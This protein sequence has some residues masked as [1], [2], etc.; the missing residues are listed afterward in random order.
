MIY[1]H[2]KCQSEQKNKVCKAKLILL[3][4]NF[5]SFNITKQNEL[6]VIKVKRDVTVIK[7]SCGKCHC[8]CEFRLEKLSFAS[9]DF[10]NSIG[11][12]HWKKGQFFK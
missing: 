12:N 11:K 8:S 3:F 4:N 2:I 9:I 1:Y 10:E 5:N 7:C 6:L